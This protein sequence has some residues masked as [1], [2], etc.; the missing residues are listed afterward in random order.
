MSCLKGNLASSE[1]AARPYWPVA[2]NPGCNKVGHFLRV[3]P[4]ITFPRE[5]RL[6]Q[7]NF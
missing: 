4:V 1:Q 6:L 2:E 5:L 3:A 7:I